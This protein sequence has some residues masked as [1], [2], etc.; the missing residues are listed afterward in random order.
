MTEQAFETLASSV[1]NDPA[2]WVAVIGGS[3]IAAYGLKMR[4]LPGF[5]L[6]AAG[7]VLAWRGAVALCNPAQHDRHVSVPY[8]KGIGVEESVVIAASP[9]KL[10]A[11]WRNFENL[12][13]VL[14]HLD[15]VKVHDDKRSH[16]VWRGPAGTKLEWE[17]EI[18]HEVPNEMIGWRS[19]DC[20][21][22]DNAGSVHFTPTDDGR[23]EVRIMLRYDPPGGRFGARIARVLGEDPAVQVREDLR[24]LQTL[25]E[26]GQAPERES[27]QE[28]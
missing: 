27:A 14:H 23:T 19:V 12:P 20:S 1:K 9:E 17:S 5:A 2:R 13:R 4:S 6:A 3:A 15:S 25:M 24:R 8:G 11:F 28:R 18:I 16:W 26:S 10:F 7:G 21:E 22:V